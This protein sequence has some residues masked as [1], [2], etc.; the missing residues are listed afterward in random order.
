MESLGFEPDLESRIRTADLSALTRVSSRPITMRIAN[1]NVRLEFDETLP[2]EVESICRSYLAP[3]AATHGRLDWAEL[4]LVLHAPPGD[5]A[6]EKHPIWNEPLP[7]YKKHS[8]STGVWKFHRD[9]TSLETN[10]VMHVWMPAPNEMNYDGL[11][12]LLVLSVQ[13]L[14]FTKQTFLFHS[15]IVEHKG[16]AVV[17]FG[18]SGIGKTTVACLSRDAGLRVMSSDQGFLHL[19]GRKL[20][21]M[22]SPVTNPDIPRDSKSWVTEPIE[23]KTMLSMRRTGQFE[24]KELSRDELAKRIF[25]EIF[26]REP[27]WNFGEALRLASEITDLPHIKKGQ[28][29]YPKG[30]DFWA[31]LEERG[32]I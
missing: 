13:D 16:K 15:T 17:L 28:L 10:S 4:R 26:S 23:V 29:S 22:A 8:E 30:F 7:F 27:D 18:P 2:P 21:A 5:L 25:A 12:N 31:S 1:V 24:T 20:F 3:F 19:D 14:A 6:S 32:L 9:F 11:D